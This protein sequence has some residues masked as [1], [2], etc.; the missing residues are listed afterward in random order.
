MIQSRKDWNTMRNRSSSQIVCQKR[1]PLTCT[2]SYH[3][4]FVPWDHVVQSKQPPHRRYNH[5]ITV[6]KAFSLWRH[7]LIVPCLIYNPCISLNCWKQIRI[8]G[9]LRRQKTL[10]KKRR[11]ADPAVPHRIFV[12][13]GGIK[14]RI[15]PQKKQ[16][17]L[18]CFGLRTTYFFWRWRET[19]LF[20]HM[21]F[22]HTIRHT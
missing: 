12:S 20:L 5:A 14:K 21:H 10:M 1:T 16:K 11:V 3:R 6:S 17:M 7:R 2:C 19:V 15:I 22:C 13:D 9:H 4:I 8:T 18:W